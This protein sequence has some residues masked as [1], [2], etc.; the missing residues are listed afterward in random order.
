MT[1]LA[2]TPAEDRQALLVQ[3]LQAEVADTL[4][5]DSPEAVHPDRS[6]YQLGMDSLMMADLIGRLR[7]RLGFST[8][9]LVFDHP[10]VAA[11]AIQLLEHMTLPA[12]GAAVAAQAPPPSAAEPLDR[13]GI[14]GYT[15]GIDDELIAFQK[16]A[17]P[18]RRADWILPRWRWMSV[19]SARRLGVDPRIWLYRDA[20]QVVGYTGAIPVRVKIG[21]EVRNSAWLV[22]TMVLEAYRSKAVGSRIMVQAHEDL[23]FALSLGQTAEMREV[24][25]RVAARGHARS[26]AAPHSP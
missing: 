1:R 25:P 21:P 18:R 6:L 19:D 7:K 5:F 24:Q 12:A 11:L 17:W 16:A 2:A 22:D 15:Q 8:A 23:P 4:G 26:R 13:D 14:E 3:L 20:G 10:M 9:A